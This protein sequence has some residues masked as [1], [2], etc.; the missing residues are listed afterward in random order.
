MEFN[1]QWIAFRTILRKEIKRFTRIWVQT[2]LPP[3]IT[4]ALYFVIFGKL[5]GS[6]IGE[7]DGFSYI[8]FVAP[9]LIMMSVLT[10]SYSNVVSSFFSAKFQRSGVEILV[11]PTPNYIILLGYCM[12]GVGRGLAVGVLVTLLSLVFTDLHIHSWVVTVAI[13]ILT[14]MLFSL[15][16]FI[17]AV[18]ANSF[19]DIS[20]IP[21][22]VLTP[23]TYLGG[24]FYSIHL[25]PDFWQGVSQL[26]PIL[27]MVNAF[28]Y[29]MLGVSDINVAGA[30]AGLLV[31]LAVLFMI[32]LH[33]LRVGKR[34]RA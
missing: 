17:N 14:S 4:M 8:Q 20:I 11:S 34:L 2:L 7:M 22:F 33:L 16:G 27:Y 1:Q 21:T 12:G 32:G 10:N 9:G 31:C 15:A 26:N 29:G 5:I 13:V 28:R 23:L 6:R 25:L 18:Y 24:V 30:F 3:A 19:D